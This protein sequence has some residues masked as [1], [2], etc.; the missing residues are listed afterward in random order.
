MLTMNNCELDRWEKKRHNGTS[1]LKINWGRGRLNK[2]ESFSCFSAKFCRLNSL[3][4][5]KFRKFWQK[6]I[7][8]FDGYHQQERL[9]HIA[10]VLDEPL[11]V[12]R[13]VFG[14]VGTG[15]GCFCIDEKSLDRYSEISYCPECIA[16]G[17]HGNFHESCWLRKCPIH[18]IDLICEPIPYSSSAKADKHLERLISL[19]DL[20]CPGWELSDGNT[21]T[22][23]GIKKLPFFHLFLGWQN[24]AQKTVTEWSDRCLGAFGFHCLAGKY[25][26]KYHYH[27]LN[28]LMERINWIAPIPEE[29]SEL[30]TVTSMKTEPEI[31]YFCNKIGKELNALLFTHSFGEL[32]YFY[33]EMLITKEEYHIFHKTAE[34]EFLYLNAWHPDKKCNCAWGINKRGGLLKLLPGEFKYYGNY[35]CPYEFAANEL[36]SI[37]LDLF[38]LLKLPSGRGLGINDINMLS[39]A[40]QAISSIINKEDEN[41]KRTFQF[42]W[43]NQINYLFDAILDKI[44]SA[45]IDELRYWISSIES[46]TQ[47]NIRERFPPNSYLVQSQNL[48]LQL[49]SWQTRIKTA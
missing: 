1:R 11:S 47:P 15:W 46:G 29:L 12:V 9:N 49:I 2:Y 13:T 5:H 17:F 48:D 6:S 40:G 24:T 8:I 20:K 43:S 3:T 27:Y 44:V 22:N 21:M 42:K 37:W 10:R 14:E 39:A 28:E 25:E 16:N 38:G 23:D 35:Q 7:E 45:H 34:A 41:W 33:K 26:S 32:I 31:K 18:Y 30:F 36:Y 4:P 19:L